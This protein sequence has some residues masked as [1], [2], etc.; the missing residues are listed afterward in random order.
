MRLDRLRDARLEVAPSLLGP[1]AQRL[2]RHA[3][4]AG[5]LDRAGPASAPG[6]PSRAS[7]AR[8]GDA[9]TARSRRARRSARR[10]RS[11]RSARACRRAAARPRGGVRSGRACARAPR[12]RPPRGCRCPPARCRRR[13]SAPTRSRAGHRAT[14]AAAAAATRPAARDRPGRARA[15]AARRSQRRAYRVPDTAPVAAVT[16]RVPDGVALVR[17]T[18]AGPMTLS[19]TNTWIVGEPAWVIDPGPA[20]PEHVA[21]VVAEAERR[22]GVAGIALTHAHLDHAAAV[23]ELRRAVRGAGG[24]AASR[25]S[26]PAGSRSHRRGS[27]TGR[28]AR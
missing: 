9:S 12:A 6:P 10:G 25:P 21:R 27:G 18:N 17:A 26:Q 13:R 8:G 1:A 20:D 16:E 14:A 2:E 7:C 3:A 5:D 19:G 28:R 23:P 24:G 22:G 11:G 15:C 4:L